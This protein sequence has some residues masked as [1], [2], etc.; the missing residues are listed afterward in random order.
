MRWL[1]NLILLISFFTTGTLTKCLTR[2]NFQLRWLE[3][4]LSPF[5]SLPVWLLFTLLNKWGQKL[6]YGAELKSILVRSFIQSAIFPTAEWFF[7]CKKMLL[8]KREAWKTGWILLWFCRFPKF[9]EDGKEWCYNLNNSH[10]Q[11][12]LVFSCRPK[13]DEK[14]VTS[15]CHGIPRFDRLSNHIM[16]PRYPG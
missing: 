8:E 7:T 5:L 14:W 2:K 1:F 11:N 10:Y 3:S 15:L 12:S 9:G 13:V 16:I 4:P 6:Q